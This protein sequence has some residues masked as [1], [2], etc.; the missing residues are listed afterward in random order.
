MCSLVLFQTYGLAHK[1]IENV[2]C[3][4]CKSLFLHKKPARYKQPCVLTS[5]T[6]CMDQAIYV[7]L[8]HGFFYF[9]SVTEM[10]SSKVKRKEVDM[11]Q[12]RQLGWRKSLLWNRRF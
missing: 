8:I 3:K 4:G 11:I 6:P 7:L 2:Y 9:R 1:I 12:S 10:T 5:K